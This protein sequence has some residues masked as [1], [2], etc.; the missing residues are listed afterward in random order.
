MAILQNA[1]GELW[2]RP[3]PRVTLSELQRLVRQ[4]A[5]RRT[6]RLGIRNATHPSKGYTPGQPVTLRIY[7]SRGEQQHVAH[8]TVTD[9]IVRRLNEIAPADLAGCEPTLRTWHDVETVLSYFEGRNV[10]PDAPVTLVSFDYR[11][12]CT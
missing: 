6:P 3:N 4:R 11:E 2:F 7:D 12:N 5:L 9:V 10:P 1:Q 8:A